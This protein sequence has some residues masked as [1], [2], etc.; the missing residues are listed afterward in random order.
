MPKDFVRVLNDHAVR[1]GE[2]QVRW[3][4][5]CDAFPSLKNRPK[6]EDGNMKVAAS[7][8][9]ECTIATHLWKN[10]LVRPKKFEIGVSKHCC[11]LCQKY[12]EFLVE[13]G[14]SFVLSPT[15]KFLVSGYQGK[16]HSG[17]HPPPWPTRLIGRMVGLLNSE[18]GE[19]LESVIR[20]NRSDSF[21]RSPVFESREIL[22]KDS[23]EG[24]F[25]CIFR[26]G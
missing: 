12:L 4:D 6:P 14:D 16:I 13:P 8:H 22:M 21:P 18:I 23:E 10:V 17:W 7:V 20:T 1:I 11:W 25:K 2:S 5:L 3:E 15:S 9:C 19:I 24:A 26:R